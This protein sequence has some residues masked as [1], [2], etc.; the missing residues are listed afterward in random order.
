MLEL[1][2][3]DILVIFCNFLEEIEKKIRISFAKGVEPDFVSRT[4]IRFSGFRLTSPISYYNAK[5]LNSLPMKVLHYG[6]S[7]DYQVFF[8][9]QGC[10]VVLQKWSTILLLL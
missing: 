9:W 5:L 4:E 3:P 10:I 1:I 2:L 6:H 7:A 8:K